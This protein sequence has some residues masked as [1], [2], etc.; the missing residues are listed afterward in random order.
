MHDEAP[1][2]LRLFARFI[3]AD[4]RE[5]IAGDLHEEYLAVRERHGAGRAR[6]WLWS[7]SLRLAL[8]F[9]WERSAHGRPLPPI[10]EELRGFGHMWDGLRQDMTFGVRMLRRQPGFT[11]VAVFA[12]ALGIGATTAIFSVVDAV[13]WRPLPFPHAERVMALAEQRPR[14]SRWFGPIAPA[15][16]FDWRGDSRS[17]SSMAAYTIQSP[18]GA[19]N[20]TGDGEP[21]RVRPLEVTAQFFDV[22]GVRPALG[23]G[24][25]AEEE[26]VGRHRVVLLSDG[27]WRRRFAA[28]PAAVGRTVAFDGRTFEIV[29][30]LPA[31][32]W[33]PSR[34][35]IV[36]PLALDGHDRTL[37]A[38][39]F[40]EAI[41]RLGDG[42]P[43]ERARQELRII[44]TRLAR[45]FP[46]ENAYHAPNMRPLRDAFVGDVHAML[47]VV[48]GAAGFVLLIACAN[49][50]TLLLARA[51]ARQRE[52]SIRTAVGASRR[53]LVQQMLT[54]SLVIAVAGGAGGVLLAAWSLSALRT[55]LPVRF[56][57]LPGLDHLGID[58][59]V[60][61][62]SVMVSLTTGLIFGGLPALAASDER[63]AVSLNEESRSGTGGLRAR[64]L[65]A[66]LVVAELALSLVLLAGASLLVLSFNNLLNVSPGF[67]PAQLLIARVT[68]PGSRYGEHER[69]VA[70]FDAVSER[71][72]AAP[73]IQHV[74]ATTSLPFDG[75]DSR[76]DLTIEH[77]TADSPIPVRV[78]PRVVSTGY[79]QT[80]G[81]ELVRGR[82][83]T[84]HDVE[85]SGR[86]VIINEAAAR[87]YWPTD[88]PIGQRISVGATDEWREIVGVVGNTRHEGLDADAEPAAYLPQHQRFES[89]GAGF[90]RAMSLVV[91]TTGDA[92]SVT[93]LIRTAVANVDKQ[94]PI[95]MVRQ[96][97]DL[98]GDSIAPRRL[99]FVLVSAFALVA[100]ALTSAGLYGVMA[101][102]VTQRT[103]EIGVRMALGASRKQ[104]LALVLREAGSMTLLGIGIGVAAGLGLTRFMATMLFGISAANPLVYV[105]MSLL[106]AFVALLAVAVPSSRATRVDPLSA[107][108]ES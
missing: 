8:T 3:P 58:L 61:S 85:T 95:G 90:A 57:G 63:L 86:V 50:A 103:R 14:E 100:L 19:Y 106:L 70:F 83:F 46:A 6:R 78:H 91:R 4:L 69:V 65:R 43:A 64:R 48:L 72:A 98:I 21:E 20:L 71:L 108:R 11:A 23:R 29:G 51:A 68:L 102:L 16:F 42:V 38:A 88:D 79:F 67:Q 35:D 73:A 76:L 89:L 54:E 84:G 62:M 105:S 59:R 24:F 75:P 47:L 44:G 60:L 53:R 56:A 26:T 15:D 49:V 33:W 92:A 12:L 1:R 96:M 40:L 13:L 10:A 107:L 30:V 32:F 94:V 74:G 93:P 9:R 22:I 18:S 36:V 34:P 27:L 39:H 37:R 2:V 66:A 82:A 99:N 31:Q 25:R 101:Y 45:E 52:V 5:P 80:M 97:D 87:R 7:Q 17:F 104:V 41:G 28:D 55:L 81:I 77:R